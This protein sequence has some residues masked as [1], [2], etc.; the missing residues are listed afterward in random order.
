MGRAGDQEGVLKVVMTGSANDSPD[1]QDHIR[2]KA[3]NKTIADQFRD[4]GRPINW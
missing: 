3:R 4:P 1:W 2:S